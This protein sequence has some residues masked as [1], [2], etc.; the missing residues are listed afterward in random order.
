V[1]YLIHPLG[2]NLDLEEGK[3]MLEE[4][5]VSRLQTHPF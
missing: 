2:N 3:R 5:I 4:F 1:F